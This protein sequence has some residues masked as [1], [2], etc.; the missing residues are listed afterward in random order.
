MVQSVP[1]SALLAGKLE[2]FETWHAARAALQA[3]TFLVLLWALV[4]C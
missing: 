2:A 3:L 4:S 1:H